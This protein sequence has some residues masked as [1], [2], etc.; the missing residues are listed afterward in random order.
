[1]KAGSLVLNGLDFRTLLRLLG[2][3][4]KHINVQAL[5]SQTSYLIG[6]G[7]SLTPIGVF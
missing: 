4:N 5:S 3:L 6:L 7:C 2:K 1:M